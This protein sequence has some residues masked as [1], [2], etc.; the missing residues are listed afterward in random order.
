M[1]TDPADLRKALKAQSH[2][3]LRHGPTTPAEALRAAADWC[4]AEGYDFDVY[5]TG[6]IAEDFEA[7]VAKLLGFP[8]ARFMPTGKAAQN[9]AMKVWCERAR[10]NHFAMHPTSHLELHEARAYEHLFGLRASLLGPRNAPLL[11][12]HLDACPEELAAL[13]IELPI[14]EAGG[15]LPTWSELK[16]LKLATEER[17]IRLHLDGARLFE[18][19][20]YYGRSLAKICSGFDS[21]YVSFYKGIGAVSGA[22]LL[23]D[24]A[25]IEEAKVWQVRCGAQVYTLA[26]N[27]ATAAMQFDRRLAMMPEYYERAQR[28]AKVVNGTGRA[29]TLPSEPHTNLMHVHL[30]WDIETCLEARDKVADELGLWLFDSVR[31]RETPGFSFYEWYVGDAACGVAVDEVERAFTQLADAADA[32]HQG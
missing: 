30:P 27:I 10:L 17:G 5:G 3:L 28:I 14:R 32:V 29:R 16:A 7:K 21:A 24:E 4:E 22:M 2:P 13:L 8:A 18:T 6:A 19:A 23:G 1:K 15:Q 26:P 25:F 20:G 12:E 31:P 9:I 11:A